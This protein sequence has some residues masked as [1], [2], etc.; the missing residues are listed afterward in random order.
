MINWSFVN[1][2]KHK[3]PPWGPLGYIVYKRT[4]ARLM[5]NGYTEEF[6]QTIFRCIRSLVDDLKAPLSQEEVENL[7][8]YCFKLKCVFSGRS[9]WQLGTPTIR[10]AGADSLQACWHVT[11]NDLRAFTF[12]FNQ[13]MLGGG[14]GAN[15]SSEF[16]YELPKVKYSP[17]VKHID[18]NDVTLIVADNR[19]GWVALLELILKAF[20]ETGQDVTYA[21]HCVREKGEKIKGFGGIASGPEVLVY[22]MQQICNILS[23]R[24]GR[25][26]RSIDILDIFNIIG[27]IVVSGNVRRSAEL[28]CGDPHDTLFLNSKAFGRGGIPNWRSMSN[29]SVSCDDLGILPTLFWDNFTEQK[30]G[31]NVSEPFGLINLYNCRRFG[32]LADGENYR[33]DHLV[34][35]TN[36]CGEATLEP[37][38]PCNLFEIF[39]PNIQDEEE[40]KIV[41]GL[42]YKV[43]KNISRYPFMES[44]VNEVVRRNNRLGIGVCGFL[45]AG[46]LRNEEIY[47]NVYR[48]LEQLDRD[49]S[50]MLGCNTSIK[51]TT[52]KPSGTVSLLA[53]VTPG[54]HPAFAPFYI[55]RIRFAG[56]DPLVS[57]CAKH[58][59]PINPLIRFDGTLDSNTVVIDF[60]IKTPTGTICAKDLTAVEQLD[61]A[62]W[63]QT[64]WSDNSVSVT[65]YYDNEELPIIL[66][67]LNKNY[68]EAIKSIS[69][70]RKEKHG[71]VQA[72]FEEINEEE[73]RKLK[74]KVKPI[75]KLKESSERDLIENVECAGGVCAI[76]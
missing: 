69:F 56:N 53:G 58:G 5:P 52:V 43:C 73:Y 64:N 70:L 51:L 27:Y 48:Y 4:Y 61:I 50:R 2:Y 22:G 76:K 8:Y 59:Y 34:T 39:L 12:C 7:Y 65:I 72:P 37:F 45:Q 46:H 32:R 18:G 63:L 74:S 6:Y 38:E 25:K 62:R 47:N 41:A 1:Q 14:V 29:N 42:A 44:Y 16:C 67:Y 17:S 13:L 35:G 33:P 55:R 23:K 9:L 10:R 49:Y 75:T 57:V 36:P 54:V 30:N 21:T 20:F 26:L 31:I 11:P 28:M 60:P 15:I 40:F 3:T 24:Y 19:E 66:G 68:S 71:F